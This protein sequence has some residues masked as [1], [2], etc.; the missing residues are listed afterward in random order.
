MARVVPLLKSGSVDDPSNYRLLS[1]LSTV[2][3]AESVVCSQWM[4]YLMAH[5]ILT[6]AQHWFWPG[7]S[8]ESAMLDTVTFLVDG[9]C[10]VGPCRVSHGS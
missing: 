9:L 8:T 2:A 10:V 6:E 4:A 3:K 7:R 1:L 5:D